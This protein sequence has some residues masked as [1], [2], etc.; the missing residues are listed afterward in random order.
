MITENNRI[1]LEGEIM[2]DF[3]FGHEVFGE[4]FYRFYLKTN[5]L[6]GSVDLLPIV[7]SERLVDVTQS[8]VGAMVYIDGQIRSY[9]KHE[10]E[11]SHTILTVFV[12]NIEN[13]DYEGEIN[14][15][16]ILQGFLC[17]E[18][19]YRKTP[20]EKDICDLILAVNRPNGRTDYIPCITWGR[21][22]IY[23]GTL[24]VGTEL[25]VCGRFQ[26]REYAKKTE[27]GEFELRT[28]YELSIKNLE[29]VKNEC[30]D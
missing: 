27:N 28:A 11:K 5:R 6:S 10:G 22:A 30:L 20:K 19:N 15:E 25:K 23:S 24:K 26:S 4:K 3:Q 1:L 7:I 18:P 2:S 9:N 13:I 16:A 17:K 21:D 14:N 29:V 8:V 12:N